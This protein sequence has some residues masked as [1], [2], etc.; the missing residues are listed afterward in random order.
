MAKA[1]KLICLQDDSVVRQF[2]DTDESSCFIHW[3]NFQ[4]DDSLVC[5]LANAIYKPYTTDKDTGSFFQSYFCSPYDEIPNNFNSSIYRDLSCDVKNMPKS[6]TISLEGIQCPN[7]EYTQL[8]CR[9]NH[10]NYEV[11]CCVYTW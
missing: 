3:R 6:A 7:H 2:A 9:G 1:T 10:R 5:Q 4:L 11:W 8:L